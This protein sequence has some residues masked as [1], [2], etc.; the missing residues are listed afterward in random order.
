M[1]VATVAT[2][3]KPTTTTTTY[4]AS[5]KAARAME[6]AFDQAIW[7][8]VIEFQRRRDRANELFNK[9]S[10]LQQVVAKLQQN[11]PKDRG[12]ESLIAQL[13]HYLENDGHLTCD[14]IEELSSNMPS[15]WIMSL[16]TQ[17]DAGFFQVQHVKTGVSEYSC[18]IML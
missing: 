5:V 11:D 1:L 14:Y 10:I 7:G 4:D 18:R 13:K 15:P 12:L 9:L 2:M 8:R 17:N 6:D 3:A 16:L